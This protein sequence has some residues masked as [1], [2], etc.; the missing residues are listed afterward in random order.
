MRVPAAETGVDRPPV[1]LWRHFYECERSAED[2]AGA[3]LAFHRKYDWDWMKV[4]PRATYHVE[5]W[6]VKVDYGNGGPKDHPT[7][8]EYPIHT[9]ADWAKLK[10]LSPSEGV[11]DEQIESLERIN[12]ALGGETYFIETILTHSQSPLT[13]WRIT[14]SSSI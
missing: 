9:A 10:P 6:G 13:W 5:D 8:V 12:E 11:L 7:V 2:L 3:M 4:N 14:M 1:S